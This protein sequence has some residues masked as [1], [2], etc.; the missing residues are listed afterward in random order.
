MCARDESNEPTAPSQL[1]RLYFEQRQSPWLDHIR[2]DLITSGELQRFI[3]GGIRG[4]TANPSIFEKAIAGSAAYDEPLRTLTHEGASAFEIYEALA[5]EDIRMAA[6]VFR[7]LYEQ[8]GGVDGRVSIEVSPRL[9][10]DTQGTVEE[11]R[12]LHR[13]ADRPNI[14]VKVPATDAGIPAIRQLLAEG[15]DIN[16][17]LIFS[18]EIYDRVIDAYLDA[19]EDRMAQGLPVERLSSVASLFVSRVDTEVDAR[20]DKLIEVERDE[21]RRR[22]LHQLRGTVAIANARIAYDHFQTV[23]N[24]DRFARFRERGAR[25]Q[26]PLWASTGTKNPAY[27]DVLYVEELIGPDTVNTMPPATIAAFQDHGRVTRTIDGD[28]DGAYATIDTLESLGIS[29][30]DV[31]EKLLADG[32]RQFAE[33]FDRLELAI[34]RKRVALMSPVNVG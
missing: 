21:R 19:L 3:D 22:D 29:M 26:R 25:V 23:F 4:V 27:R 17:T 2:R 6:D 14:F 8:S 15:I 18:T 34:E 32:L 1:H 30:H 10:D 11:A 7:P 5:V 28:A 20:L 33:A 9:A 13:A 16:I 24:G 31:T 12:R